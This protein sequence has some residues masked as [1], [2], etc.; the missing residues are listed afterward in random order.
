MATPTDTFPFSGAGKTQFLLSLLLHAQLAPPH[1]L[2]RPTLYVSTEHPLPTPRLTQILSTSPLITTTSTTQPNHPSLAKILSI[3]TPDLE[4]Q[5]HILTYQLPV[6]LARHDIGLVVIDSIAANYRAEK[7][8]ESNAAAMASR[9]AHLI[10]VGALLRNL[11]REHDCAIVVANQVADRFSPLPSA[12]TYHSRGAAAGT[13]V[14]PSATQRSAVFSSSPASNDALNFTVMA[15]D[16]GTSPAVMSLDHQ[17][18]FFT[19]WGASSPP[20]HGLENEGNLKT[21][22]LGLTWANQ[23]ACRIALIKAPA[24]AKGGVEASRAR[25]S[26]EAQ[27]SGEG[28]SGMGHRQTVLDDEGVDWA[29]RRWRRWMKVVFAPWAPPTGGDGAEFEVWEGGIRAVK[30]GDSD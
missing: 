11:A 15:A 1:G 24:F 22:S 16:G 7:S 12:S 20:P 18:R 17:Q 13:A 30:T 27:E 5:D 23:I 14:N 21:P 10:K 26:I 4:S 3:Q 29:P 19:G 9:S 25:Q 2:A 6:A 8:G 28:R